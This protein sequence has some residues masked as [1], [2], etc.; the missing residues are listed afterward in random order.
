MASEYNQD[1]ICDNYLNAK[2]NGFFVDIGGSFHE[3]WNNSFFFEK[4]RNYR[5][6]AI[7]LNPEYTQGWIENR[8]NTKFIV[9]D[10]TTQ[11]YQKHLDELN[12]P[13]TIDFLSID[14][15]PR[16]Q[17]LAALYKI[18]TTSYNFSTIAFE[19]D[20]GHGG[21]GWIDVRDNSREFL[22]SRDYVLVAEIYKGGYHV[23]DI[24]VHKLIHDPFV[25]TNDNN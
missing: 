4:M 9:G 3:Q 15:D 2:T 22:K 14:I 20:A 12:A 10:A 19:V 16:H 18:F 21:E 13:N 7:D 17:S 11:D 8:P 6:L 5:G 25:I 24:W 23:D 1:I